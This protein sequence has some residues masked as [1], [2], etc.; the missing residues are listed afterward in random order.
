MKKVV[1]ATIVI[2]YLIVSLLVTSCLLTYNDYMVSVF[3]DDSL[4]IV[5]D[6]HKILDYDNGT[7]LVVSKQV[8]NIADNDNVLYYNTYDNKVKIEI[9]KVRQ[10]EKITDNE[11][12]FLID[13]KFISSEYVIG[14]TKDTK[15]YALL[16][17]ILGLLESKW[18][19]LFI[20]ILPIL[21]MF[22]YEVHQL[23]CELKPNKKRRRVKKGNEKNI[24]KQ[25][26]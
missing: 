12:T 17:S 13:D 7:L 14:S 16:G 24:K 10:K 18:G 6:N 20:I 22:V 26:N 8:Q 4:I 1:I 19:Y 3:G 15:S 11:Y 25:K 9:G 2:L 5:N 21:I 23:I